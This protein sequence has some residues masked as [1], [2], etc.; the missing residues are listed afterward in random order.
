MPST[1]RGETAVRAAFTVTGLITT[2]PVLALVSASMLSVN[3]GITDPDP[4]VL[5]LLQHRGVLQLLLGAALVWAAFFPPV[6][7]VAAP[8]AILAK[9]VFLGLILPNAAA[10]PDLSPLSVVFDLSCIAALGAVTVR[11]LLARRARP[12]PRTAG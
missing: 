10:R 1:S 6:R 9:S 11:E 8:A 7:L 5:A 2:L 3:Y 12:V 4:M